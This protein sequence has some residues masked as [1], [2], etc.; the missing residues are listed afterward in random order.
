MQQATCIA[1]AIKVAGKWTA[2]KRR[3][4]LDA[5]R[6][7]GLSS[8]RTV[9]THLAPAIVRQAFVRRSFRSFDGGG[10]VPLTIPGEL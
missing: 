4:T 1:A 7:I 9:H 10:A 5:C 6:S 8:G 2:T 3:H